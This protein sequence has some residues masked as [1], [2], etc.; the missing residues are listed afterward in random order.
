MSGIDAASTN[1]E[2]AAGVSL[3]LAGSVC[4]LPFLLPY[5]QQPILSFQAEWLAGALG[6]A[7]ALAAL[8]ARRGMLASAP[9][10]SKWLIAFALLL[11]GQVLTGSPT[12]AQLPL[13][14]ALYVLYAALLVWLGAQ[15][16]ASSGLARAATVLATCLLAGAL[17]NAA[18]GMIQFYGRPALLEHIVAELRSNPRHNGAYGN[19]AQPNL[20]ANYLAIGA[21][22]LAYLWSRRM[23]HTA[24]ALAAALL[25]AWAGALSGSRS[26]LLYV[27]W[28]ALLGALAA[29]KPGGTT[30]KRLT[31]ACYV[32][33]CAILA[34][35]ALVPWLNHALELGPANQ[36]ALERIVEI[37]SDRSEARWPA[38]L[39]AWRVF[40]EAP[41]A[42][43]GIGEFAGAAFRLG[44]S[45]EMARGEVWNSA[46][47]L[48]LQ[49]LAETGAVG[50]ALALG[51]LGV[52]CWQ[53]GRRYFAA[54]DAALWWTIAAAGMVLAHSM[55]EFPLW[56]AHFLGV[57]A[58][59]MGLAT[60]PRA[61]AEAQSR[62]LRTS[63]A[64]IGLTLALVLALLL[65]DYLRL[66]ATRATGTTMTLSSPADSARDAAVMRKLSHGLLAPA[67]EVWIFL[68]ATL[69][70]SD[71]A[72]KIE[73]SERV[74]RHLP[75]NAIIVRRAL[76]LALDGQAAA[77]R[78]LLAHAIKSFPHRCRQ[79]ALILQRA[80]PADPGAIE[81]LVQLAQNSSRP[82]CD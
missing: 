28:L 49:L 47:N 68:G 59:V 57:T 13:L 67:A 81:P 78:S 79:T 42:G 65:R 29:R 51:G 41:L 10:L 46:H 12:Y 30:G 27:L 64:G 25:L 3:L 39:L 77:A 8:A 70:R 21:A 11:A 34:A 74:A 45:A 4:L 44:L 23:L 52:W 71:L 73:L 22:A 48:P 36:G 24:S 43:A 38:W 19:I 15:L 40:A 54:P 50:A 14:A 66:D 55:V 80:L 33:A 9:P 56:S 63:A 17:A 75:A 72:Y 18:A 62:L 26:A 60:P 31:H 76:F 37:A 16:A 2:H 69:D 82:G 58:L 1:R 20:Y 5:H 61:C 6:I 7:A 32:L 35:Q 53:T